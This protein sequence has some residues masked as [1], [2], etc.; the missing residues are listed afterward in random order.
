[1]TS[2]STSRNQK[3]KSK[4]NQ[5]KEKKENNKEQSWNQSNTKQRNNSKCQW[6]QNKIVKHLVRWWGKTEDTD[7]QCHD[8]R[9]DIHADSIDIKKD[10][11]GILTFY[12]NKLDSV[13]EMDK[14]LKRH[15]L[16]KFTQAEISNQNSSVSIKDIELVV[17]KLPQKENSMSRWLHWQVCLPYI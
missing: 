15:K 4:L 12:A 14:F 7:H 16:A 2:A 13:I 5:S 11:K 9:G 17:K 6:D 3:N 1:M 8:E 10:N